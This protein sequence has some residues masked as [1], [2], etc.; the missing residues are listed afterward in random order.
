MLGVLSSPAWLSGGLLACRPPDAADELWISAQGK[1]QE[2][3]GLGWTT[4]DG[5]SARL[6]VGFRGHDVLPHALF[7]ERALLIGRHPE[8]ELVEVDLIEGRIVRRITCAPEHELAGH[9]CFSADGAVLFTTESNFERGEGRVVARDARD[10]RVLDEW[11][12][13]GIGPHELLRMPDGRTLAVANGGLL[14]HP[15]SGDEVLNLDTM[16][17][18]LSFIDASSGEL[19][20]EQRVDEQ[21]ASIRHLDVSDRGELSVAL[22]MQRRG[23][24]DQHQAPLAAIYDAR[25]G[26]RVISE[27]APLLWQCEDYMGSTRINSRS[28][29]AGFTSPRGDIALFWDL[30]TLTPVGHHRLHDVC[31]LTVSL[32]EALFVL[33]SSSGQIRCL[34]AVTLEERAEHRLELSDFAW[35]NHMRSLR[36]P[37]RT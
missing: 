5:Q 11:S 25:R 9:A 37:E 27:P 16:V 18:T 4:P 28:R 31:G 26:L 12:S 35:D 13:H 7:A 15:R 6:A 1:Q 36:H 14:T 2:T 20:D 19:L 30:D 23:D 21:R 34:D 32:D 24:D 8:R 17:S 29:V 10:Y 33:S 22:Q 3:F